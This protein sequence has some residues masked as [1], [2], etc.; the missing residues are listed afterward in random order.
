MNSKFPPIIATTCLSVLIFYMIQATNAAEYKEIWCTPSKPMNIDSSLQIMLHSPTE[1]AH[2]YASRHHP[3]LIKGPIIGI[4]GDSVATGAIASPN[5]EATFSSLISQGLIKN[6][7]NIVSYGKANSPGRPVHDTF[8]DSHLLSFGQIIADIL[9]AG[10]DQI[11]NLAEDGQRIEKM[12]PQLQDLMNVIKARFGHFQLPDIIF[13]S[14]NANNMCHPS[15]FEKSVEELKQEYLTQLRLSYEAIS[16]MVPAEGGTDFFV[17]ANLDAVSVLTS[18]EILSKTVNMSTEQRRCLDLRKPYSDMI[19]ISKGSNEPQTTSKV[20]GKANSKDNGF[21]REIFE[22]AV[23]GLVGM[24]PAI[25]GVDITDDEKIQHLKDIYRSYLEA[26]TAAAADYQPRLL[27][28]GIRLHFVRA[29]SEIEFLSQDV[30][31]DCF[32]PNFMGQIKIAASILNSQPELFQSIQD[33][34]IYGK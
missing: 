5:I 20:R 11:I 10:S 16:H 28:V 24:C 32:H 6:I 27:S 21:G 12:I 9:G 30:G 18:Q 3:K 29:T 26:Q 7:F 33:R 22:R 14:F 19:T 2:I 13:S 17:I 31:N 15:I 8:V 34:Y 4:I 25:L 1:F 23:K